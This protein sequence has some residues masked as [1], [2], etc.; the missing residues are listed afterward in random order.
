MTTNSAEPKPKFS[1]RGITLHGL[2][3]QAIGA[4]TPAE[5]LASAAEESKLTDPE[6]GGNIPQNELKR[7]QQ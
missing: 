4:Q 5:Q 7:F 3:A 6:T 2:A 1:R